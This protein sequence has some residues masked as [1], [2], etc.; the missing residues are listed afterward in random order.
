MFEMITVSM[1]EFKDLCRAKVR[2]EAFADLVRR[3]E[4]SINRE[5]CAAYLGFDLI[6]K[7]EVA[8]ETVK[9]S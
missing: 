5:D 4:F 2:I 7:E 9:M 8:D 3:S 1:S 6:K